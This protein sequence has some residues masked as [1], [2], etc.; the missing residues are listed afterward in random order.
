MKIKFI[1]Y[2]AITII[3]SLGLTACG[4]SDSTKTDSTNTGSTIVSFYTE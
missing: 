4:G 1:Y 3:T 2:G